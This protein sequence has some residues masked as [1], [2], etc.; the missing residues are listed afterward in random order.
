MLRDKNKCLNENFYNLY[1]Y[2][3]DINKSIYINY[4]NTYT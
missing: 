1:I 3:Y 2:L 4:K